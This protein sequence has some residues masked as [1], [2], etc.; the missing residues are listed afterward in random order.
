VAVAGRG[1]TTTRL[2]GG[3]TRTQGEGVGWGVGSRGR[4]MKTN[5]IVHWILVSEGYSAI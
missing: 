1:A 5:N 3:A 2:R 4:R